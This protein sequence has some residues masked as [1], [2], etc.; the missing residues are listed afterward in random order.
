MEELVPHK[1]KYGSSQQP[2]NSKLTL[3]SSITGARRISL[4][5]KDLMQAFA[6]LAE[7]LCSPQMFSPTRCEELKKTQSMDAFPSYSTHWYCVRQQPGNEFFTVRRVPRLPEEET[8]PV[9]LK[10]EASWLDMAPMVELI[11]R[12]P[13]QRSQSV[14]R[15]IER[16]WCLDES[17]QQKELKEDIQ[18]KICYSEPADVVLLPCRHGG[19][20]YRCFRRSLF[21]RPIHRGG[22]TCPTCRRQI[23]DVVR[24]G[25]D[26]LRKPSSKSRYGVGASPLECF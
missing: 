6:S 2:A 16:R 12:N 17:E 19:M 22:C 3:S 1:L 11:K 25:K 9:A 21:M 13:L 5:I 18:C 20:C 15:C 23:S 8:V 26:Q 10:S 24:I 14:P 4:K 7:N